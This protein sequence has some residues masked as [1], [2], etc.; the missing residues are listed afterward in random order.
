LTLCLR[1][2]FFPCFHRVAPPVAVVVFSSAGGAE[3]ADVAFQKG[4]EVGDA[5]YDVLATGKLAQHSTDR[6]KR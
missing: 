6:R 3:V 4:G 1:P 5:R 2:G